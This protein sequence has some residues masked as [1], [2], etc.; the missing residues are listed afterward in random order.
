MRVEL[1]WPH[2][3]LWPNGSAGT[4]Q[5]V[6][7]AKKKA[8]ND[9]GWAAIQARQANGKFV[10][11]GDEIPVKLIVYPKPRGPVPD[12]DNCIAAIKVMLDAIAE[13]IGVNDRHFAAP[14][15]EFAT[16][17]VGKMEVVLG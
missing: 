10:H 4:R 14:I 13:Q 6:A 5:G 8:R 15:V 17:R 3:L 16:P 1:S 9:A 2:P 12:K 7:G 11:D